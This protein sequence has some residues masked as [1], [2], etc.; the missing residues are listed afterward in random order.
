MNA[1]AAATLAAGA[2]LAIKREL[3][4]RISLRAC[5]AG[6][7]SVIIKLIQNEN[8]TFQQSLFRKTGTLKRKKRKHKG[9]KTLKRKGLVLGSWFLVL[10]HLN[11]SHQPIYATRGQS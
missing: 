9:A 5:S 7:K 10:G 3:L 8:T 1:R 4:T 11:G 2:T 6:I